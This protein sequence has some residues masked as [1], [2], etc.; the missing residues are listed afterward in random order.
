MFKSNPLMHKKPIENRM[1][2]VRDMHEIK[3]I[4]LLRENSFVIY[5]LLVDLDFAGPFKVKFIHCAKNSIRDESLDP[6]MM[7]SIFPIVKP[8]S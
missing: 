1:E 4:M 5:Q 3:I 7:K 8:I 2:S 6:N